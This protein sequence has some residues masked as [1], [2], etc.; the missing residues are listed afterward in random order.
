MASIVV[1]VDGSDQSRAALAWAA[2]EA[3]VR[4]TTLTVMFVYRP[5]E[6]GDPYLG[7]SHFPSHGT[8][9]KLA[10]ESQRWLEERDSAAKGRAERTLSDVVSEVVAEEDRGRIRKVA[11]SGKPARHL[12]EASREAE[13]LVVGSRGRGGFKDLK[14][15]S[16]SEQCV[17][18]ARCPVVVV[19]PDQA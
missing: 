4:D 7:R 12:I 6:E 18:H 15:G 8:V 3:G 17:R 14:L 16:V 13:M 2:E 1:G 9:E 10:S 11:V 5:L 19:H